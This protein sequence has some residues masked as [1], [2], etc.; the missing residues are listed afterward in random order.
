MRTI[1]VLDKKDYNPD[2]DRFE[3]AAVRGIIL[4]GDGKIAM[5]RSEKFGDYK[6]LGGGVRDGECHVD[7]LVREVREESGLDVL[8]DSVSP[9]GKI[10]E[11]RKGY[12][13][14]VVFQQTSYYYTCRTEGNAAPTPEEGYEVEYG[15]QP[16]W[17]LP[18]DAI[19]V[20]EKLLGMPEI[21]WVE[22][23]LIVLKELAK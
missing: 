4:D 15:Y 22:R 1:E 23:E 8:A 18:Q 14:D 13:E 10:I 20:N 16:V 12:H 11:L 19:A 6:F 3:R 21:G 5:V 7:T 9:Y 17:V 2:W